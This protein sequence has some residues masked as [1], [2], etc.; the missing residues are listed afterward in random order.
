MDLL[1]LSKLADKSSKSLTRI[2]RRGY[3]DTHVHRKKGERDDFVSIPERESLE[4][5][6]IDRIHIR[7]IREDV[8]CPVCIDVLVETVSAER[9]VS[10]VRW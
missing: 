5:H 2:H 1:N 9:A 3:I 6:D 4:I 7:V 10:A 8:R